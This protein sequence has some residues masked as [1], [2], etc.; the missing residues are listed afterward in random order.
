MSHNAEAEACDA[1]MEVERLD[2]LDQYVDETAYTRVCLYLKRW[3]IQKDGWE[4]NIN[5]MLEWVKND[6]K[7]QVATIKE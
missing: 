1:L 5:M 6:Y 4:L 3:E 2:D 7:L